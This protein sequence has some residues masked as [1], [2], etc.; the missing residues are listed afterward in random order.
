MTR[1]KAL[2]ELAKPGYD[3]QMQR[4][5]YQYVIKKLGIT[6]TE[7]EEYMA[8]PIVPHKFYGSQWDKKHFRRYYIFKRL[9]LPFLKVAAKFRS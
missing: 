1:E 8:R 5:D 2:E 4:E 6:E 3:A 7:F 9:F